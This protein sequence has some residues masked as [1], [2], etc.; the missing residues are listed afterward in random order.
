MKVLGIDPGY[1]RV[2]IA[3]IEKSPAQKESV[4]YSTCIQ[5]SSK[6]DIYVRFE[7]IGR[8]ICELLD[9]YKPEVAA[10][11]S[12]FLSK[13]QKTAM[14]VAEARGI[15]IYEMIKRKIP[16]FEYSP[17]QIKSTVTGDGNCDKSMMIKMVTLL[18]KI[19]DKKALDDEF[20]AIAVALTHLALY[21]RNS[22]ASL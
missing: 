22:L 16:V 13:N 1:D 6:D 12:L 18:V 2:G 3:V 10:M 4:I 8:K 21:K 14:R 7:T 17:V 19:T 9:E 15:I 11:E 20:D 5:T